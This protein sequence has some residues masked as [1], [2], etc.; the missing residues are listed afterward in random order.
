VQELL[1]FVQGEAAGEAGVGQ[2]HQVVDRQHIEMDSS[3]VVMDADG[4]IISLTGHVV[5]VCQKLGSA[6]A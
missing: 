3:H 6:P 5:D 1:A 4:N 2:R